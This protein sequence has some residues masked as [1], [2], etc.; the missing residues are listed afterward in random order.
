M[1]V[2]RTPNHPLIVSG[3]FE[4]LSPSVPESVR[5]NQYGLVLTLSYFQCAGIGGNKADAFEVMLKTNMILT[6][7]LEPGFVYYLQGKLIAMNDG[8]M[9]VLTYFENSVVKVCPAGDDQPSFKSKSSAV[10]LGHVS[11]RKEVVGSDKDGGGH[12]EVEVVHH[13]WDVQE[14]CH[15]RFLVKY[16]IPNAKNLVKTHTL[17]VV[18]T[19]IA[20]IMVSAVSL[21]SG[22]L[23]GRNVPAPSA[24]DSVS[25]RKGLNF[26]KISPKKPPVPS[27]SNSQPLPNTP[28]TPR[29]FEK[30]NI[31]INGKQ[32]ATEETEEEVGDESDS[33]KSDAME[34]EVEGSPKGKGTRASARKAILQ[35]AAKRMK[36]L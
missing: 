27:T 23:I 13:D 31:E 17:Y 36:R 30:E 4:P 29:G 33:E 1:L 34:I 35:S 11:K 9:P 6:H 18:D 2:S 19:N 21:T 3:H 8:S 28:V 14:R 20:V 7:S 24:S 10:G 32:K 25:P 16:I 5:G 12:L 15:R 26:I 22:H